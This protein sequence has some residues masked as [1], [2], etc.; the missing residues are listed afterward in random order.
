MPD[1]PGLR[2]GPHSRQAKQ[3]RTSQRAPTTPAVDGASEGAGVKPD[4]TVDPSPRETHDATCIYTAASEYASSQMTTITT[5]ATERKQHITNV[6]CDTTLNAQNENAH[7][8][9]AQ[10]ANAACPAAD[11][12]HRENAQ[13][14]V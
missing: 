11:G 13:Y 8:T 12:E 2:A 1:F 6:Y 3:L 14:S 4:R 7:A 10:Y 9:Y 5:K